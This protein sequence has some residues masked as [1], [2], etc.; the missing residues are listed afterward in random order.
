M[1]RGKPI[2]EKVV[3]FASFFVYTRTLQKRKLKVDEGVHL[4][5]LFLTNI[6][7]NR[8]KKYATK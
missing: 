4:P 2:I 7:S 1:L 3:T 6:L 8:V 5:F